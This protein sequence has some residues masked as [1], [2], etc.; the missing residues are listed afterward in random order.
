ME[1]KHISDAC[2]FLRNLFFKNQSK[3]KLKFQKKKKMGSSK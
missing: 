1:S 2:A 3:Q